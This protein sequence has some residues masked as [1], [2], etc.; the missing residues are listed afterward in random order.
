MKKPKY[1]HGFVDRHGKPRYYFRREGSPQTALPGLPWSPEFMA[2]YERAKGADAVRPSIGAGRTLPGTVN[3]AVVSYYQSAVLAGLADGT[4]QS[5]RAILERFRA[6]HGDKRIALF[7]THHLEA[8]LAK[9]K[10]YAARNWLK[11]LRGLMVHCVAAK[12]VRAN[13]A[14]AVKLGRVKPSE[15]F[16]VWSDDDVQ[17]F[18]R[19]HPVGSKAFLALA[20]LRY[21]GLARADLVR[22]GRQHI[23]GS[24]ISLPRQ[25]TGVESEM[26]MVD[27]L[28]AVIEA[29]PSA[30]AMVFLLT[31]HGKAFTAAGFGNWFA[32]RCKEAGVPTRAHGLRKFAATIM[33][34][35]GATDHQ[36]MAW[37]GWKSIAEAQRYTKSANR[38]R[39]AQS[40]AQFMAGTSIGKPEGKF[41][42][43][44]SNSL[45]SLML[46]KTLAT[47]TGFEPVTSSLEGSR[48][49]QLS[50]GAAI[51]AGL[52]APGDDGKVPGG[53]LSGFLRRSGA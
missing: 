23:R 12:L 40:G 18:E 31:E 41:A 33:A 19:R 27:E 24:A 13:P 8:I 49:I 9:L 10:P 7:E 2:A 45:K 22:F 4:R 5:R 17:L 42:N 1:V 36:L 53:A 14:N 47:P 37:F 34:E 26:V 21:T 39:L 6:D 15:G 16:K 43:F 48:S 20:L 3:A 50:Y 32:D 30:G 28:S 46:K 51:R 38:K 11:A 52:P 25:K 35:R 44:P 29:T